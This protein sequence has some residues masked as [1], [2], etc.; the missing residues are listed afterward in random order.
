MQQIITI[1]II[2]IIIIIIT[3]IIWDFLPSLFFNISSSEINS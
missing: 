2:I 1:I 3:T